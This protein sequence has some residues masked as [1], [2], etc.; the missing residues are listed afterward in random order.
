V[1]DLSAGAADP[2]GD[3]RGRLAAELAQKVRRRWR[4]EVLAIG[5]HGALAHDDDRD[6]ADIDVIVVTYRPNTGPRPTLRRVEGHVIDLGVIAQ[7]DLLGQARTLTTRWPLV[8]DRYLHTRPLIDESGWLAALRDTHL[9]RLADASP[10]EFIAL[11]REAWC[12][13]WSLLERA[14]NYGQWHNED[15]A[16]LLL[17]EARTA[18][19]VTE[20]LL[21]RTYFRSSAEAAQRAQVAGLDLIELRERLNQQAAELAKR[22]RPVDGALDDLL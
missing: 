4:A 5:V 6:G 19:A 11:A 1:S 21:T 16:L 18:T 14:V 9:G 10:R 3:P 17:S 13:A 20:G 15:G 22:G 12:D 2:F 7:H 8:A